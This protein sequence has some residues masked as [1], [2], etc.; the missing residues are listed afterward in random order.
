M[1]DAYDYFKYSIRYGNTEYNLL[2]MTKALFKSWRDDRLK[3]QSEKAELKKATDAAEILFAAIPSTENE[4]NEAANYVDVA[5]SSIARVEASVTS[6][7]LIGLTTD[8]KP[9][10]VSPEEGEDDVVP[11]M[12]DS[13]YYAIPGY[14]VAHTIKTKFLFLFLPRKEK[15]KEAIG[16]QYWWSVLSLKESG[17]GPPSSMLKM[18]AHLQKSLFILVYCYIFYLGKV[19]PRV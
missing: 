10:T 12:L 19:G 4:A 17:W 3:T 7:P 15:I 13:A 16:V 6:F 9:R 18:A 11:P 5:I 2:S 8:S 14:V 1:D